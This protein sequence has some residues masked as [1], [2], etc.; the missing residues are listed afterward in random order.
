MSRI[1]R[2]FLI[3]SAAVSGNLKIIEEHF[4]PCNIKK[5]VLGKACK[6]KNFH[7]FKKFIPSLL[8]EGT[9][10]FFLALCSACFIGDITVVEELISLGVKSFEYSITHAVSSGNIKIVE[11]LIS[12]GK[13]NFY[14]FLI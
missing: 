6:N 13:K 11:L 4:M 5:R 8:K 1:S 7:L 10:N 2:N 14:F 9:N 3:L 12:N